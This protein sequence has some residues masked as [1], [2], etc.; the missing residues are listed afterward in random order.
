MW[1]AVPGPQLRNTEIKGAG[2]VPGPAT[3]RAGGAPVMLATGTR[4]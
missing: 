1:R 2:K 4:R 3:G